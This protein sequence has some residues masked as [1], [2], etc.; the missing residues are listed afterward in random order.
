MGVILAFFLGSEK[1][2]MIS[3]IAKRMGL[4]REVVE[5]EFDKMVEELKKFQKVD[6]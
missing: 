3:L 5:A 1:E 2:E 6:E 4:P